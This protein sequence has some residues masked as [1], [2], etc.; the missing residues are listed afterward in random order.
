MPLTEPPYTV[1]S[2]S[3]N[4]SPYQPSSSHYT[5]KEEVYSSTTTTTTQ[6]SKVENRPASARGIPHQPH[7][8]KQTQTPPVTPRQSPH[9]QFRS[10]SRDYLDDHGMPPYNP[11]R[12]V[13]RSFERYEKSRNSLD[14]RFSVDRIYNT[15]RSIDRASVR[16]S[17]DRSRDRESMERYIAE[18]RRSS[19]PP[20]PPGHHWE[21]TEFIR[22]SS[23]VSDDVT[24]EPQVIRRIYQF[25]EILTRVPDEP[26]YV[27]EQTNTTDEYTTTEAV[28]SSSTRRQSE[29]TRRPSGF[30][31][32]IRRPASLHS[33]SKGYN[34][35]PPTPMHPQHKTSRTMSVTEQHDS[36]IIEDLVDIGRRRS[37]VEYRRPPSGSRRGSRIDLDIKLP[38]SYE[39]VKKP[40]YRAQSLPH[41]YSP[42]TPHTDTEEHTTTTHVRRQSSHT[43]VNTTAD[44]QKTRVSITPTTPKYQPIEF[45]VKLP[46]QQVQPLTSS[47]P[48]VSSHYAQQT[49]ESVERHRSMTKMSPAPRRAS[50]P[51]RPQFAPIEFDV[52]LPQQSA[53]PRRHSGYPP[54]YMTTQHRMVTTTTKTTDHQPA[55]PQTPQLHAKPNFAPVVFDVQ[56]PQQSPSPNKQ[57]YQPHQPIT[58]PGNQQR[59][60]QLDTQQY[61]EEYT[62]V[63]T[64][65]VEKQPQPI[66]EQQELTVPM[67]RKH[68]TE[69]RY[70]PQPMFEPVT[71]DI[72]V[73]KR[74]STQIDY[75]PSPGFEPVELDVALPESHTAEVNYNP[76]K[77]YEPVEINLQLPEKHK[78][79]IAYK[80]E[81]KFETIEMDVKLPEQHETTLKYHTRPGYEPVEMDIKLDKKHTTTVQYSSRPGYEP[82]DL[83]MTMPQQHTA[84]LNYKP[85][86]QF[87]PIEVDVKMPEQHKASIGFKPQKGFEPVDIDV[88]MPQSHTETVNYKP[89]PAY[90]PV[91]IDVT[92]P[93]KHTT[94]VDFTPKP[95]YEPVEMEMPMPEQH[96]TRVNYKQQAG[97]E[98]VDVAIPIDRQHT[99]TLSYKQTKTAFEPVNLN[100]RMPEKHKTQI[101]IDQSK[102]AEF[103][104]VEMDLGLPEKKPPKQQQQQ[105]QPSHTTQGL[106]PVSRQRG[107]GTEYR[108]PAPRQPRTRSETPDTSSDVPVQPYMPQQY[109][110]LRQQPLRRSTSTDQN[111][112]GIE[113]GDRY[114]KA[115][116]MSLRRLVGAAC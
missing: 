62:T 27:T 87:E 25:E 70:T 113:Q 77:E 107:F 34:V 90:E 65:K 33:P 78:T 45:D 80:P 94:Q 52:R 109:P 3:P 21:S 8:D 38:D 92:I 89:G 28:S 20:A 111:D 24:G 79:G 103:Q 104:P 9:R 10:R 100:I 73:D 53:S 14:N 59:P 31:S 54:Q 93:K 64:T 5:N 66:F 61:H 29:S 81:P 76:G 101:N 22:E 30:E 83:E 4:M 102:P 85:G 47:T 36:K 16:R 19:M 68:S 108:A 12:S 63:T 50:A 56:L 69:I 43:D 23:V 97:F 40:V 114:L 1:T 42:L 17:V 67:P 110:P 39:L 15:R 74:H 48:D 72:Q 71:M 115:W 44:W 26:D 96:T 105:Q 46:Q 7:Y 86:P 57:P 35:F 49:L 99:T 37:R 82:V 11:R 13:D 98:P 84:Q 116:S 91:E 2:P 51:P 55:I 112:S 95:G 106:P 41:L 58:L 88:T 6:H 75:K 60:S 32:P 18:R